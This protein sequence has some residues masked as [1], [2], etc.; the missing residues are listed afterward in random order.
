MQRK[1]KDLN[2]SICRRNFPETVGTLQQLQKEILPEKQAITFCHTVMQ[3]LFTSTRACSDRKTAVL[4]LS[5]R[6]KSPDDDWE[7][8]K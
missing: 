2:D 1:S 8:L 6:M 5:I 4:F 3:S 7:K